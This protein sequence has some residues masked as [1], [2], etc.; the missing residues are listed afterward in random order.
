[1]SKKSNFQADKDRQRHSRQCECDQHDG[2]MLRTCDSHVA[3]VTVS[4]SQ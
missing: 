1:M 2:A 3:L 4:Q